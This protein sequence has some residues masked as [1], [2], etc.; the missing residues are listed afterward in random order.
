MPFSD[1]Q[2]QDYHG[3][4]LL[5]IIALRGIPMMVTAVDFLPGRTRYLLEWLANGQRYEM[6][7]GEAELMAWMNV[8]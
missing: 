2:T 7:I 8:K 4:K 3:L 5:Q 6:W 1:L